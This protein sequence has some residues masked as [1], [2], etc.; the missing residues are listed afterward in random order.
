LT[1]GDAVF[2]FVERAAKASAIF[3]RFRGSARSAFRS[4]VGWWFVALALLLVASRE[5]AAAPVASDA[6]G[7]YE[8]PADQP[9][10]AARPLDTNL[11]LA[12]G[13]TPGETM[14]Y[15]VPGTGLSTTDAAIAEQHRGAGW[16]VRER[17]VPV[18]PLADVCREHAP[19]R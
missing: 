19:G 10:A 11:Q 5:G 2:T 7:S 13:A 6:P 9:H 15:E 4:F 18:R 3:M 17:H 8:L 1:K 16:E 14:L 12:L